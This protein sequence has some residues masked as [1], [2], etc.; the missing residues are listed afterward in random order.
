MKKQIKIIFKITFL[1]L[2][3]GLF[4]SKVFAQEIIVGANRTEQYFPLLK[5]KKIGVLAHPASVIFNSNGHTHLIDSLNHFFNIVKIFAPEHGFRGDKA[6]G[7]IVKDSIDAETG[8]PI[9]SLYGKNKRPSKKSLENIDVMIFD[10]QDVGVRFYTYLSTLHYIMESCAKENIPLI[11]L[12]RPNPNAHYIDGPVLDTL[13]KSFVGLHPVPIVYGMTI[14]EYAQM[15]NGENWLKGDKKCSLSVIKMKNYTHKTPY[16]LA[17]RP[18]PNLPNAQA[19]ALYPSL[20]FFEQTPISIGRGTA[21]PFQIYGHPVFPIGTFKFKP[22]PNFGSKY[23]KLEGKIC[24][25]EDLRKINSPQEITLKWLLKA[26][27]QYPQKE[28]FFKKNF[29]LLAGNKDL[30]KQIKAGWGAKKIKKKWQ[31]DLKKFKEIRKKYLLYL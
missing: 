16:D 9:L 29:Y 19:I 27:N 15:I 14:G 2:I 1:S 20:C 25:G 11:L 8:I 30:E 7:E 26:Y 18:S 5:E 23:P 6:N 4:F 21:M 22:Y 17:I 28:A 10:L 13:Y 12:D 3:I 31:K 24:Y